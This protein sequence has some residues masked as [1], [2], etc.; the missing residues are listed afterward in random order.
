MTW[1][2]LKVF[3]A[4]LI[5]YLAYGPQKS[6]QSIDD[7]T[8]LIKDDYKRSLSQLAKLRGADTNYARLYKKLIG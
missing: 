6:F 7:A 2:V 3:L 1:Y 8:R 5:C 4:S